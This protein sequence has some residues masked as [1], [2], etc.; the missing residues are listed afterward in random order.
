VNLAGRKAIRL[1][2]EPQTKL[3]SLAVGDWAESRFTCR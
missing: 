3:D 2:T 1:V